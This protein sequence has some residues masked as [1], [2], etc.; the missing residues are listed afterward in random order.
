MLIVAL[1]LFGVCGALYMDVS[2]AR[3]ALRD[4]DE[5]LAAVLD[6]AWEYTVENAAL[7]DELEQ[8]C[9]AYPWLRYEEL[10]R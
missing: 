7:R 6:V 4:S 8:L 1:L 2:R 9:D 10:S 3:Q 5:R